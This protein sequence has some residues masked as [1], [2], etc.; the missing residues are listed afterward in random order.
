MK[1]L[2][3]ALLLLI[4][5]LSAL[6]ANM[7]HEGDAAPAFT[8]PDQ[9]GVETT[10]ES[11]KGKWL[12]LY[13]YPKDFSAGCSIQAHMFQDALPDFVALNATIAGVSVDTAESHKEFCTKQGLNFTLLSDTGAVASTAYG[14]VMERGGTT[15]SARNTFLIDPAGVVRKAYASVDPAKNTEEVLADL[16]KLAKPE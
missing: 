5:P 15:L 12:V 3:L 11:F 14:S 9:N 7:P 2:L 6:A 8:L 10:L 16:S 13:F 4:A 1:T